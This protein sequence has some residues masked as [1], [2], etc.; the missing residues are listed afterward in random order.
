MTDW[1]IGH[2]L[3]VKINKKNLLKVERIEEKKINN[4][5]NIKNFKFQ[6]NMNKKNTDLILD[7]KNI[8]YVRDALIEIFE[9]VK[10]TFK[11]NEGP[12]YIQVNMS[13]DGLKKL[14]LKSGIVPLFDKHSKNVV[15]WLIN[16]LDQVDQS[17]E[18]LVFTKNFVVD[19]IVV[20]T[21]QP[22]GKFNLITTN[23]YKS[24]FSKVTFFSLSQI[25]LNFFFY[26]FI[27]R[28]IS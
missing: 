14:Y 15:F 5:L 27:K 6:V 23:N 24:N 12:A 18:N 28:R 9:N 10:K 2:I 26:E 17:S 3:N 22:K 7:G 25:K 16:Q 4:K 13:F 1:K 8:D 11:K 20:K 21:K 19:F